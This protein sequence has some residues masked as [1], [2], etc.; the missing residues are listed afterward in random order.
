[1]RQRTPA[2]QVFYLFKEN[3]YTTIDTIPEETEIQ[4]EVNFCSSFPL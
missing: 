3:I 1:M 4:S 2:Q